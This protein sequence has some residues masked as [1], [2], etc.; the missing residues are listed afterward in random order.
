MR[1]EGRSRLVYS[2]TDLNTSTKASIADTR[3]QVNDVVR[4]QSGDEKSFAITDQ[5]MDTASLLYN[6]LTTTSSESS[7]NIS[8][9]QEFDETQ[10]NAETT[11]TA[12]FSEMGNVPSAGVTAEEGGPTPPPSPITRKTSFKPR[13]D[14]VST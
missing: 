4:R 1:S 14:S 5:Q 7:L 2:M 3:S 13:S 11:S 9:S 8:S 6:D 12:V 10:T